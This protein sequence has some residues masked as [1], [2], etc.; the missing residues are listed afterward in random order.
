M[1]E[2]ER[3][4]F[5]LYPTKEQEEIMLLNC[6]NARFAYNWAI[7]RI[8]NCITN[9]EKLPS[10]YELATEFSKFKKQPGYEWLCKKPASQRATKLEIVNSISLA[11]TKF[12]LKQNNLPKFHS[13]KIARMSYY[14]HEGTTLYEHNRVRL[15]NLGW[16]DCNNVLP[17]NDNTIKICMPVIIYTG[18]Y[19][20]L[21]CVIKICSFFIFVN[22][23]FIFEFSD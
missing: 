18:D 19:W 14:S 17:L 23:D 9:K 2:I 7:N 11:I 8:C 20:E 16:V 3:V 21:S 10:K 22:S 4:N 6:H 5:R 12:R 13:K 1:K 15:E